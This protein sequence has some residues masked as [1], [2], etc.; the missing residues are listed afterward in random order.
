[1]SLREFIS[2][3][4]FQRETYPESNHPNSSLGL[5]S[6]SKAKT[7]DKEAAL[8][9]FDGYLSYPRG[10]PREQYFYISRKN[11]SHC[12][13]VIGNKSFHFHSVQTGSHWIYETVSM[14]FQLKIQHNMKGFKLQSQVWVKVRSAR[15]D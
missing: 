6:A 8:W 11:P 10:L 3:T 5:L 12:V 7:T 9:K 13:E 14:S 4:L 1:M 15:P 2:I